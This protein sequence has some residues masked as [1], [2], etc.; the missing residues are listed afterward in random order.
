MITQ[1][2]IVDIFIVY[3]NNNKKQTK[4][5]ELLK[6]DVMFMTLLLVFFLICSYVVFLYSLD[7][8]IIGA[9]MYIDEDRSLE[10]WEAGKVYIYFQDQSAQVS[11]RPLRCL[12]FL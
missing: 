7:D 6:M 2:S 11:Q 12:H 1:Q 8:L 5:K 4:L 10:G 3:N 9:P